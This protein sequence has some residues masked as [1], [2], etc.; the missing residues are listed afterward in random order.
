VAADQKTALDRYNRSFEY[1]GLGD[2]YARFILQELLPDVEKQKATNGRAIHLLKTGN[3]RAIG[4]NSSGA[5]A[6]FTAAWEKPDEFARVFSG[7]G[8]YVGLRGGERYSSLIRKYEPRAMRVFLQDGSNDQNSYPGDWFFANQMME[9]SLQF[10]GTE[11]Q[12]AWGEGNHNGKQAEAVFPAAMR[13]LWKD[14]Q[15]P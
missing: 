14:I 15:N 3:D 8:T 5:I 11:V 1:D 13:W 6:A 12:H 7:I 9:R 4:G 10:A 2:A